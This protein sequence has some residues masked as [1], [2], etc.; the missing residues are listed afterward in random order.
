MWHLSPGL[1]LTAYTS[2]GW[3]TE[4]FNYCL[5][6]RRNGITAILPYLL[7]TSFPC[8]LSL[9][10]FPSVSCSWCFPSSW[11]HRQTDRPTD[12]CLGALMLFYLYLL[13]ISWCVS[14]LV[15]FFNFCIYVYIFFSNAYV[16]V[17]ILTVLFVLSLPVYILYQCFQGLPPLISKMFALPDSRR[18]RQ[19]VVPVAG[20]CLG[21]ALARRD[22]TS[23]PLCLILM[24][25][26]LLKMCEGCWQTRVGSQVKGQ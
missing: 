22:P 19:G 13:F 21:T 1:C 16:F 10:A 12:V 3:I 8:L 6:C 14:L 2:E 23:A 4:L 11:F 17:N 26:T 25:T 18:P 24:S 20:Q 7:H 15:C 5:V 9:L